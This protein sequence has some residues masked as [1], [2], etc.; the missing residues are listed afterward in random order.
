MSTLR[1]RE[2]FRDATRTLLAVESVDVQHNRSDLHVLV[3]VHIE[4]IAV[5]VSGPA[6]VAALD[7]ESRPVSLDRL[8]QAIPELANL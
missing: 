2:I 8:K 4:P 5:I 7:M 6:G 1:A 3:G